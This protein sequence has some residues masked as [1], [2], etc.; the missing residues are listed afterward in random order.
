MKNGRRDPE[1][2]IY[3][4]YVYNIH[5]IIYVC[6]FL[7]FTSM[8]TNDDFDDIPIKDHGFVNTMPTLET[9]NMA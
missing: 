1:I 6:V 3:N 7:R 2:S 5:I 4:L 8:Y 9:D